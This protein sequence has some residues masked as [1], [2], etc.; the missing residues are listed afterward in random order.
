MEQYPWLAKEGAMPSINDQLGPPLVLALVI[1][2]VMALAR[3][4]TKVWCSQ[5]YSAALN[6]SAVWPD[7]EVLLLWSRKLVPVHCVPPSSAVGSAYWVRKTLPIWV[8]CPTWSS[9]VSRAV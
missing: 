1:A 5:V 9:L 2:P 7:G 4:G 8:L 6:P 3:P